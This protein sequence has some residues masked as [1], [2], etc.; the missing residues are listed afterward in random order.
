[1]PTI[2]VIDAD[3]AEHVIEGDLKASLMENLCDHD[4][5]LDADCGGSCACATCHVLVDPDWAARLSAPSLDEQALLEEEAS[6]QPGRSRLSCQIDFRA[7]LD[8]LRVTLLP[9]R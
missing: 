9:R 6:Y 2:H 8:G 5:P 1:M 4:L 7:E 3:G